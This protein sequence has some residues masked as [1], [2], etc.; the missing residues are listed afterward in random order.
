MYNE[1]GLR[2][3]QAVGASAE[4]FEFHRHSPEIVAVA[5][6]G[7]GRG[8]AKVFRGGS[9]LFRYLRGEKSGEASA[10][11]G[12]LGELADPRAGWAFGVLGFSPAKRIGAVA[13]VVRG[14]RGFRYDESQGQGGGVIFGGQTVE[15]LNPNRPL[16]TLMRNDLDDYK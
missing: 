12:I 8:R 7:P 10:A 13:E 16:H 5:A 11:V 2:L 15:S 3:L 6:H 1:T 14:R 4:E 9:H